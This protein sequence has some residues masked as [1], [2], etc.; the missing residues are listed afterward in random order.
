MKN[1]SE[2]SEEELKNEKM[3]VT[4]VSFAAAALLLLH[5]FDMVGLRSATRSDLKNYVLE[6]QDIISTLTKQLNTSTD[7]LHKLLRNRR[8]RRGRPAGPEAKAYKAL[9]LHR[10]GV[11]DKEVAQ[12]VGIN[13]VRRKAGG[14]YQG[15]KEW[16]KRLGA[17]LAKGVELEQSKLPVA[18]EVFAHKDEQKVQEVARWAY[19]EYLQQS[20]EALSLDYI[21]MGGSVTG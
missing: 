16:R 10:M 21:D 6:I 1:P 7:N 8:G 11:K 12:R 4:A 19:D 15:T 3:R 9:H 20:Y 5:D 13:Y 2:W 18:A 14:G 17:L